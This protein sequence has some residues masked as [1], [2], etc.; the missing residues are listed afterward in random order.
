MYSYNDFSC[1]LINGY[2]YDTTIEWLMKDN[3]ID[4]YF[5]GD[6]IVYTGRNQVKNVYDMFDNVFEY[7]SEINYDTIVI[8]GV[9]E[10]NIL[11]EESRYTVLENE[12][13][14]ADNKL[15]ARIIIYR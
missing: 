10:K 15:V 9:L 8:R 4:T 12:N 11:D 14:F 13:S 3:N 6:S 2:A 7:T 5:I 1:E